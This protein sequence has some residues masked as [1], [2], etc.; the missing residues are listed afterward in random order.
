[1]RV[2]SRSRC[3]AIACVLPQPSKRAPEFRHL[4]QP[5]SGGR[6]AGRHSSP[7]SASGLRRMSKAP[8][9]AWVARSSECRPGVAAG[10]RCRCHPERGCQPKLPRPN[11]RRLRT[12]RSAGHPVPPTPRGSLRGILLCTG[13]TTRACVAHP[14]ARRAPCEKGTPTTPHSRG[15]QHLAQHSGD[16]RRVSA[17]LRHCHG[18]RIRSNALCTSMLATSKRSFH[19]AAPWGM[20]WRS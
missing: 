10:R 3:A 11:G 17:T 2:A 14:G 7:S 15:G 1:M 5:L 18:G 13:S 16:M 12:R 9:I 20:V 4:D 8:G 19:T 6:R